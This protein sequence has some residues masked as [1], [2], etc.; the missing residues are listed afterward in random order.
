MPRIRI[1]CALAALGTLGWLGQGCIPVAA[2]A[3]AGSYAGRQSG[4]QMAA[5]SYQD[6][7]AANWLGLK[8]GKGAVVEAVRSGS[9]AAA[10]GI[11]PGDRIVEI[12]TWGVSTQGEAL[13]YL[14]LN[15]ERKD[16]IVVLHRGEERL[17]THIKVPPRTPPA[18]PSG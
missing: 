1:G 13:L 4:A 5:L 17:R 15:C 9:P 8:I 3:A 10:E 11:L 14:Y 6:A 16:I 2:G 18:Q 12:E 7:T